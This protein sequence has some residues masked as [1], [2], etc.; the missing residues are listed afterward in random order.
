MITH[1]AVTLVVLAGEVILKDEK[2]KKKKKKHSMS[3]FRSE[4]LLIY[5]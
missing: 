5:C 1:S 4:D 2:S 3:R